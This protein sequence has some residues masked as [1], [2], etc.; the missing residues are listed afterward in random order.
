MSGD[1]TWRGDEEVTRHGARCGRLTGCDAA[2]IGGEGRWRRD[3]VSGDAIRCGDEKTHEARRAA[4]SA[5]PLRRSAKWGRGEAEE[6]KRERRCD[7]AR[8]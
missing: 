2:P 1:V 6:G 4:R 8:R 5:H 7:T 3:G